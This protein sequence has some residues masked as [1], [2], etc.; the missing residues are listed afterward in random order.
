MTPFSTMVSVLVLGT[1]A[2]VFTA[3]LEEDTTHIVGDFII[4]TMLH[5]PMVFMIP[6][7]MEV[8]FPTTSTEDTIASI[9]EISTV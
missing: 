9:I 8:T 5:M 1:L 7:F 2:V 4:P 3:V 6:I